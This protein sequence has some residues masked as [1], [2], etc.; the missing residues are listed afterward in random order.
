MTYVLATSN[1]GKIAEMRDILAKLGISVISRGELG[2]TID[3]LETGDT[4][5]ENAALKARAICKVSGMPAIA[6]DSGLVV[7]ALRGEP[8]LHTATYGGESLTS[9]QRCIYL[10]S[11][12]EKAEH[13]A[14]KFVCTIVCAFP[15]GEII[16]ATGECGGKISTAPRGNNG[17]GYDPVFIPD[18]MTKTMAELSHEEKNSISHRGIALRE[19]YLALE[20]YELSVREGGKKE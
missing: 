5:F 12:M 18:K 9:E 6:D 20:T 1:P 16:T 3:I 19:F 2:I 8:G 7:H 17:F 4:F 11:K 14:A 15:S 10:L 13:R